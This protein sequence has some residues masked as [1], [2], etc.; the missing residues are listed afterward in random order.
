LRSAISTLRVSRSSCFLAISIWCSCVCAVIGSQILDHAL[1]S[2]ANSS[3]LFSWSRVGAQPVR[4]KLTANSHDFFLQRSF[5]HHQQSIPTGRGARGTEPPR[6]R[7]LKLLVATVQRILFL[8]YLISEVLTLAVK[9]RLQ[10]SDHSLV[11][12]D[13][14]F[15]FSETRLPCFPFG[16]RFLAQCAQ[17]RLPRWLG[18]RCAETPVG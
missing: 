15:L 11:L 9:I 7:P 3:S 6:N 8:R 14:L 18:P 10:S 4:L 12:L 2:S 16:L 13:G 17:L 1:G 5:S